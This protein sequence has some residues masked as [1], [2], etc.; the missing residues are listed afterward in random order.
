MDILLC[1]FQIVAQGFQLPWKQHTISLMFKDNLQFISGDKMNTVQR[2]ANKS[3]FITEL[4]FMLNILADQVLEAKD[5]FF[6]K[7]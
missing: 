3:V 6:Y 7:T 1:I 5:K 2:G 4:V